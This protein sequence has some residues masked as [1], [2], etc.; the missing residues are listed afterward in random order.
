MTRLRLIVELD[1]PADAT[2]EQVQHY[3]LTAVRGWH[4]GLEPPHSAGGDALFEL[5]PDS[6]VVYPAEMDEDG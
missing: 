5:D 1:R 6:V 3:V 4:G 2:D